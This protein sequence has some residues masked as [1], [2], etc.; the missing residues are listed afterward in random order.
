MN[1]GR[2]I[3]TFTSGIFLVVFGVL[4]LIRNIVPDIK[5]S[6]IASLWPLILV[7]IGIEIIAAY[8]VNKEEKLKYDAGAVFLVIILCIFSM[9]MGGME[10]ILNHA[11]Q[12]KNGIYF[13]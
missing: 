7:F 13:K 10:F 4:Y 2:R 1:K 6:F 12:F 8:V 5:L 9:C 11:E 3:G